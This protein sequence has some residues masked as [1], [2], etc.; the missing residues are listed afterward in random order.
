ML[1]SERIWI[2]R[3]T[4][5]MSLEYDEIVRT[6]LP[7][8]VADLIRTAILEGRLK[9]DERLPTEGELAQR[10]GISRPTVREALKVLA[11]QNLIRARR[12]PS[13]GTFVCRPDPEAAGHALTEA[14]TLMVGVGTFSMDEIVAARIETE[15][16]CCRMA[17]AHRSDE[18][19]ARLA[20]EIALQRDETLSD[21]EFCASDVRFHRGLVTATANGPLRLMM[22]AVIESFVP[23]TNMLIYADQERRRT[24]DGHARVLAAI[25]A[26]DG[27]RAAKEIRDHLRGMRALLDHALDRRADRSP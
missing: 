6:G 2:G 17:A 1:L 27:D 20:D 8:Q 9:V 18:D 10:F 5:S 16:V 12:G 14:A 26:R 11:A 7:R 15:A 4:R 13:G 3:V 24:V 23:V 25:S 22:S 21:E 19:L